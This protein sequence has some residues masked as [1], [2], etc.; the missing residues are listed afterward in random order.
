MNIE[1]A[2]DYSHCSHLQDADRWALDTLAAEVRRLRKRITEA[3]LA[4]MDTRSVLGLCAPTE[5]DFPALYALQGH[6]VALVDMGPNSEFRGAA[7]RSFDDS[8]GTTG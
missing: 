2:M 5:E 3:P 8:P 4:I 6:R 1:Q 7:K